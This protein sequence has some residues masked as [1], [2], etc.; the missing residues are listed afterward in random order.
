[1]ILER[2][3]GFDE[4]FSMLGDADI[5]TCGPDTERSANTA[6][7]ICRTSALK[8]IIKHFQDHFIPF[9][10]YEKY[11]MEFGNAEGRFCRAI[12]DLGLKQVS[13]E[14]PYNDQLHKSGYGTWYEKIGFRHIHAE[15]NYAY[16]YKGIPPEYKYLDERFMGD[17]YKVI[18]EYWETKDDKLL[19]NWWCKS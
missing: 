15:H 2:P 4:L 9:K 18:K 16:R 1:M 7:F 6:G 5:M 14:P 8:D 19:E 17:E 10:N 11:T 13:V 12:K 3:E